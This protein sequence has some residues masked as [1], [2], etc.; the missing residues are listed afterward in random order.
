[1]LAHLVGIQT[2]RDSIIEHVENT[3]ID[4]IFVLLWFTRRST[5]AVL[6][7]ASFNKNIASRLGLIADCLTAE[8][9][10]GLASK[11]PESSIHVGD[12]FDI[13]GRLTS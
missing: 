13:I 8:T 4:V 11:H 3:T 10:C 2:R 7:I 9:S 5:Y 1:M 6:K 12:V